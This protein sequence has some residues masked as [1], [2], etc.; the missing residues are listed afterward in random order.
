MRLVPVCVYFWGL[1]AINF[2]L[3]KYFHDN[4][5]IK[6]NTNNHSESYFQITRFEQTKIGTKKFIP[7]ELITIPIP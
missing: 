6:S 3:Q 5:S 1:E 7:F 2:F 4:E